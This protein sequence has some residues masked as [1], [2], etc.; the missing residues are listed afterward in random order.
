MASEIVSITPKKIRLF[1][2]ILVITIWFQQQCI[3]FGSAET[4]SE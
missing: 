1:Y 2:L 3:K 4:S